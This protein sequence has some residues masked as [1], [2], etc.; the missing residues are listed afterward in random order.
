MPRAALTVPGAA[1]AG[2]VQAASEAARQVHIVSLA[3]TRSGCSAAVAKT[4]GVDA[5]D[6]DASG[7]TNYA[8][9]AAT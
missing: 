3:E 4:G 7:A 5:V 8:T 9:L 1:A 6:T 2:I